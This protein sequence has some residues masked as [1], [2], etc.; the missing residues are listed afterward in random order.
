MKNLMR[1]GVLAIAGVALMSANINEEGMNRRSSSGKMMTH[2]V[3]DRE[4]SVVWEGSKITGG[5]HTGTMAMMESS[6]TFDGSILAGGS[7]TIDMN[8]ITTTDLSGGSAQKLV[9]H[10]KSDDFFGVTTYPTSSFVITEVKPGEKPGEY[11]VR[12]DLTIKSTT[13]PIDFPVMMN[14]EG[15]RAMATAKITIDRTEFDVR[16]GSGKFF[17]GLGDAAIRD[18]FTLDVTIVSTTEKN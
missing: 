6:L 11:H 17:D 14:W 8:S 7:F 18:E 10:L 12:G 5:S 16:Y 2:K 13:M 4:S 15:D 9:G 1:T 3:I